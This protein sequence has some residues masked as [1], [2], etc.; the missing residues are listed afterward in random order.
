MPIPID[1]RKKP[2][3]VQIHVKTGAGVDISWADG[4]ESHFDFPYLRDNCPCATCNDERGKKQACGK[5]PRALRSATDVQAQ[6][7]RAVGHTGR[8]LRH[9]DQLQ[10]WPLHGHFQLRL[11][12]FHVPLLSLRQ[13]VP[14]L[15][16]TL[17]SSLTPRL[18]L[19]GDA[20]LNRR[21]VPAAGS[22]SHSMRLSMAAL[23]IGLTVAKSS[24]VLTW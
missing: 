8:Q 2:V 24:S 10:R 23:A 17:S 9:P 1:P 16:G 5:Q 19:A 4:H 22:T 12:P 6:A 13:G 20:H 18:N 15:S 3:A 11:S 7:A 21:R 14:R